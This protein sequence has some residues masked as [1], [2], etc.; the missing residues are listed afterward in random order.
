[1]KNSLCLIIV[2]ALL[3]IV[4]ICSIAQD[5]DEQVQGVDDSYKP[6]KIN[7]DE[8][9]RKY[10]R[11]IIWNQFW[12][13][14]AEN[15]NDETT[16]KPLIRRSRVLAFAQ[17]SE[18]FLILTHF[19]L[20][21]LTGDN[22]GP[23]GK[24]A[25]AQLFLHGAWGEFKIIDQIHIGGGLHYWNGLSRITSAST[26]NFMTLDNYRQGWAQLGLSDQFARHMG[27]YVKGNFGKLNYHFAVNEPITNNLE[28]GRVPGVGTAVYQGKE[29]QSQT[30]GTDANTV[31]QGYVD[32]QFLD[33]ESNKLPYRV[34][35][36]LGKK[37]VFNVGAGF[38]S[39][40]NGTVSQDP[41]NASD[42]VYHNVNHFAVDAY[43]DAPVAN[44]AI[45]AYVVY[46]NF[47]YGPNYSFG[48]YGTGSSIYGQ[49]GFLLPDFSKKIQVMPYLAYSTRDYE[50]FDEP[51]NTFQVGSNIFITGHNAKL[52][53]EY[54]TTRANYSGTEPDR[55]N[56]FI[57][58]AMVFL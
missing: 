23:V 29:I 41:N 42:F 33:K 56:R 32:Y 25:S 39:H 55:A 5:K 8:S 16:F 17:I 21:T 53:F 48:P 24:D 45:N 27:V 30:N 35:S 2:T 6:L 52:T 44:G 28:E 34:G 11:F 37:K 31:Y 10:V 40:P 12:L 13:D 15:A 46:Y 14:M 19:G 9:G 50:A 18:R 58:Q 51:G 43:Y 36:Y 22:M 4:P 54:N 7:I 3:L 49:A 47:D 26:L 1:M 20:N 57:I 38:F